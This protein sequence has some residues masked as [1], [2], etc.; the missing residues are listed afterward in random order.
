MKKIIFIT[1]FVFAVTACNSQQPPMNAIPE[2]SVPSIDD[3][4]Y[5]LGGIGAFG[6]MV[7]VGIKKL[8]LSA[9]LS[10]ED[11]DALIEEATRVAKRN[12]VEIYR[13][14]DFLVTDL[15][16]AS[17]TDGKHVLVIYKGETKQEYLDLKIKKAKLVASNQYTGL[18]REEIARQ[19]GAMLSY[20]KWKINELINNNNSE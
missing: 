15:F 7:N 8:A 5:K 2:N 10:P 13:E 11:M 9:A 17:V 19:F 12:N 16:P 1:L 20:P 4:S 18:A 3:R 6:E 14:K